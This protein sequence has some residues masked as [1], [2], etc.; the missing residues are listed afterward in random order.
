MPQITI[1]SKGITKN[2]RIRVEVWNAAGVSKLA[3]RVVWILRKNGYD[4]IDWGNFAVRQKK[5]IIKDLTGD[6]ESSH[7]ISDIIGCGEVITRYDK[8]RLIDI[9]VIL[10]EDCRINK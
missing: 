10:G 6:L 8:K 2:S 3:E 5:T 1:N 9:S 7:R 4:V